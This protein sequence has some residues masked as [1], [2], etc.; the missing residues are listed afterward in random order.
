M[1]MKLRRASLLFR[2]C[3]YTAYAFLVW[4]ALVFFGSTSVQTRVLLGIIGAVVVIANALTFVLSAYWRKRSAF[5]LEEYLF[6]AFCR[7]GVMLVCALVGLASLPQCA[8]RAF[9]E[10]TLIGYYA[11]APLHVWAS[12]PPEE[13]PCKR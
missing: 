10:L 8:R 1:I 13:P 4:S 3:A 5:G 9:A 2:S 11:T 12:L 6:S 7:T